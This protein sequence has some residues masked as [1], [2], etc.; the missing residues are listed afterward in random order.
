MKTPLIILHLFSACSLAMLLA[1]SVSAQVELSSFADQSLDFTYG[2]WKENVK[3]TDNGI[4]ISGGATAKGGGGGNANVDLSEMRALAVTLKVLPANRASAINIILYSADKHASAYTFSLK[5]ATGKSKTMTVALNK[6]FFQPKD[7]PGGHA[8]LA[9]ITSFQIQGNYEGEQALAIEI[10][11]LGT[12]KSKTVSAP[13]AKPVDSPAKATVELASFADQS[14]DFTYGTWKE[15]V[16]KT[17]NGIEISGGATAK[18]GG[19]GKAD[20]DLSEMRSLAVTLQVLPGN[21]ASAINVTL[22]SADK[23]ASAYTF[24]LKGAAGKSKTMTLAL[25]KPFFQPK[26]SPSG[27]A[28]LAAIT[29]FQIQGNYEGEQALA[30]E[31]ERLEAIGAK[32]APAAPSKSTTGSLNGFKRG[33]NISHWLSQNMN[34]RTYGA[35]WFS[36]QDVKWISEQGFD[37]LRIPVD[38]TRWLNE[39][40][41][42]KLA[43]L[44]PFDNACG[45]ARENG[46]GVILDIHRL[47]GAS[48]STK[49]RDNSLFS[50]DALLKEAA[51]FWGSVAAHYSEAGSWL[52]FELLNEPVAEQNSQLNPVLAT[53]LAAI[54]KSNPTRV[55]YLTSNQWS[56]FRTVPDLRFPDDTNIALT[57]HFYDPPPFTHQGADWTEYKSPMPK[58]D[59]PG[60][61]PELSQILPPGHSRLA[62]S[63]KHI[64]AETVIDPKFQQLA[65]WAKKNAPGMAIHIGEFGAFNAA[66]EKSIRNYYGAVVAAAERHGFGWAAWDYRGGFAIRGSDG[67]ATV[68]MQGIVDGK[69]SDGLSP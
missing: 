26:D 52:R 57:V 19:G 54:R 59:F 1:S 21:R 6:P 3:K 11:R 14:L 20:V 49:N 12:L 8:D 18:G 60:V 22:Y 51:N 30:I 40:S 66:P 16:K 48:S 32:P 69:T 55:V 27:H 29:S 64:S 36:D 58:F 43:A 33:V 25:N 42:L 34:E 31:I 37:H 17:D 35:T 9:A 63:G 2:T 41:T 39:D 56:K 68:A 4:E 53:L 61:V 45:W 28:D 5:G 67:Q 10:E 13:P 62:L 44:E 47:P 46:L 38:A 15:N 24:S 7:S 65:D 23:H 50:N